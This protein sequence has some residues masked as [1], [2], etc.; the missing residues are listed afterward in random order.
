MFETLNTFLQFKKYNKQT[1]ILKTEI[2][3]KNHTYNTQIYKIYN[4]LGQHT[5]GSGKPCDT[6]TN[7]KF[8]V[9]EFDRNIFIF[10]N[11]ELLDFRIVRIS[12]KSVMHISIRQF[13]HFYSSPIEN[14]FHVVPTNSDDRIVEKFDSPSIFG[15]G[16]YA[17]NG[18]CPIRS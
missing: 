3:K 4:Q 16:A 11:P 17:L 6:R 9:L 1:F 5:Q 15:A 8:L 10:R 14:S 13:G 12:V 2:H 7:T 18:F